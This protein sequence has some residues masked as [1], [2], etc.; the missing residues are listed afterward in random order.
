MKTETKSTRGRP[1][2]T[3]EVEPIR[4]EEIVADKSTGNK[5]VVITETARVRERNRPLSIIKKELKKG[6]KV[7]VID[8]IDNWAKTKDGYILSKQIKKQ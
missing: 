7:E 5:Y 6:D 4:E 8:F 3:F 2:K 1:K